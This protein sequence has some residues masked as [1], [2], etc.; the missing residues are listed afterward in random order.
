VLK[1]NGLRISG[2][3]GVRS[4]SVRAHMI[5]FFT[6]TLGYIYTRAGCQVAAGILVL[7]KMPGKPSDWTSTNQHMKL[8]Q[9]IP[10]K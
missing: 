7:V 10:L 9:L 1:V 5:I 3:A 4:G 8:E 6:T 2:W